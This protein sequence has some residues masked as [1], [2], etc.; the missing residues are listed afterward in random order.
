M[1][2]KRSRELTYDCI[3]ISIQEYRPNELY[4]SQ[5][6]KMLIEESMKEEPP[7]EPDLDNPRLDMD[8]KIGVKHHAE[9]CL[10]ELIDNNQKILERRIDNDII[11][12]FVKSLSSNLDSKYVIF[13]NVIILCSNKPVLSNQKKV[14]K[15][16]FKNKA[17]NYRNSL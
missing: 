1:K 4:A 12:E 10:Q 9:S 2:L 14:T 8:Q 7:E 6:L 11:K 15:I 17:Y 16:I 13:L 3:R 5:W